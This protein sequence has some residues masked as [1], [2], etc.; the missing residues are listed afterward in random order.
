MILDLDRARPDEAEAL[1][2][3]IQASKAVWGYDESLMA[4]FR[5]VLVVRPADL[6]QGYHPVLRLE[7]RPIATGSLD[8]YGDRLGEIS[9]LFVAPDWMRRGLGAILMTN[10][11][12]AARQRGVARLGLDADPFARPFYE[13]QGFRF[14]YWVPSDAGVPGRRLARLM[15][16]L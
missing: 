12:A 10:L 5:E 16:V 13:G 8:V 3:L 2:E 7:G 6:L 9:K 14:A 4:S 1:T 15:R 11:L